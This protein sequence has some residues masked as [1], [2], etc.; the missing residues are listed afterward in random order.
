MAEL[1]L[2]RDLAIDCER[3]EAHRIPGTPGAV[4]SGSPFAVSPRTPI[5]PLTI[6]LADGLRPDTLERHLAAGAL[7]GMAELR[8]R[9][10]MRTITTVFPSVTGAAYL[11]FFTGRFPGPL[12]VPGLRW[13]DRARERCRFPDYTRSYLG[14]EMRHMTGDLASGVPTIFEMVPSRFAAL[15][16][17]SRGLARHE[18]LGDSPGFV[19]RA[20]RAHLSGSVEAWLDIDRLVARRVVR[21]AREHRPEL[22][23]AALVGIDKTS[24][25]KGQDAPEVLDALRIVD[26]AVSELLHDAER[27]GRGERDVLWIV[28]DHGHDA[29]AVH[30]DLAVWIREAGWRVISHP[31]VFRDWDVAVMASGNAMAHL[32]L[33]REAR[34]APGWRALARRWE[35]FVSLLLERDSVDLAALPDGPG[36][37]EV[38]RRGRGRAILVQEGEHFAYRPCDG[39]PLGIGAHERLDSADAHA[40]CAESEFPDAIVQLLSLASARRSGDV[41]VSAAPGYDFRARFESIPHVSAHGALR[42]SQMLVPMLSS[43]PDGEKP[44]RTADLMKLALGTIERTRN[45]K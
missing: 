13:Y 22:L 4:H 36:R 10:G 16:I 35:P 32:Y 31:W 11:P 45:K 26:E 19:W 18:R 12:G 15:S 42:R 2:H 28:S 21:H 38:R 17:I 39:D 7:P 8:A 27:S 3:L 29:I 23:F 40:V 43:E 24:H 6:L 44:L 37:C 30:D 14:A 9:C 33:G 5:V 34:A 25:A 1:H 20:A 41:I